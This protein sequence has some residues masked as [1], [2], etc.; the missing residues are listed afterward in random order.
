[1]AQKLLCNGSVS[2]RWI[3][4]CGSSS[5]VSCMETND[6]RKRFTWFTIGRRLTTSGLGG[7]GAGQIGR[8]DDVGKRGTCKF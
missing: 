2:F 3:S 8:D 4:F 7:S 5:C 1:M 6:G